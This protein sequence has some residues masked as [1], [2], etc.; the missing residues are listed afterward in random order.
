MRR[1]LKIV[2]LPLLPILALV[3]LLFTSWLHTYHRLTDEKL[4]AELTFEPIGERHYRVSLATGDLCQIETYLLRGDQWR[5]DAGFIKWKNWATLFG[6]DA[7][8]RLD[9]LEG[10][11][12]DAA[13]QS[14]HPVS[15]HALAQGTS[16]DLVAVAEALG[17]FNFLLDASY[18]SSV[19][20]EMDPGLLYKVYR[21]QSGLIVRAEARVVPGG[22]ETL[23]IDI[24]RDCGEKESR[25]LGIARWLDERI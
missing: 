14:A 10:R 22:M 24:D 17:R 19:Y 9:R 21:T 18:G 6:L 5:L 12:R 8:Y 11:Y 1:S 16:M 20:R 7:M 25:W 15:A 2:L 13:E 4:V 23:V 3:A